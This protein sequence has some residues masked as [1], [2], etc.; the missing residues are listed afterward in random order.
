LL[1]PQKAHSIGEKGVH[2]LL[3]LGSSF[4]TVSVVVGVQV[5]V[6]C[7]PKTLPLTTLIKTIFT[8]YSTGYIL[9]ILKLG[10]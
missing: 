2:T 4:A 3:T 10:I 5:I 9:S 8:E 7:T 6:V 1:V